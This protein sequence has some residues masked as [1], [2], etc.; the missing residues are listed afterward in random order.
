MP[1]S[2]NEAGS[3]VLQAVRELLATFPMPGAEPSPGPPSEGSYLGQV[4]Q[5][6]SPA[7]MYQSLAILA[8]TIRWAAHETSRTEEEILDE[9][10]KNYPAPPSQ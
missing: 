7:T 2:P 8:A 6:S 1:N 10:G 4:I 3:V 5:E 9:L